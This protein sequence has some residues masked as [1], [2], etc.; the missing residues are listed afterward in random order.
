MQWLQK[1][2]SLKHFLQANRLEMLF[3]KQGICTSVPV[4]FE[5]ETL[6]FLGVG[7]ESDFSFLKSSNCH[8]RIFLGSAISS[9]SKTFKYLQKMQ[10]NKF[11]AFYQVT[12][13]YLP[14]PPLTSCCSCSSSSHSFMA[15]FPPCYPL[16]AGVPPPFLLPSSSILSLSVKLVS[17]CDTRCS[18]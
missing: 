12:L 1:Y 16:L 6:L 17:Q 5:Y 14:L 11:S 9:T 7:S 10:P 18:Q 13:C 3:Q 2:R 4:E 8:P 15:F